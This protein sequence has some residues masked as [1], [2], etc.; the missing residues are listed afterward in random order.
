MSLDSQR[1]YRYTNGAVVQKV[2]SNY[3]KY[4]STYLAG[5]YN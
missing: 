3:S 4:L 5:K 2:I 1:I